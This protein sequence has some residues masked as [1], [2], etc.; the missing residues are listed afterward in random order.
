MGVGKRLAGKTDKREQERGKEAGE[1]R[2]AWR[3]A[4]KDGEGR[5]DGER[6]GRCVCVE[7]AQIEREKE[8][9]RGSRGPV[10][11]REGRRVQCGSYLNLFK[12]SLID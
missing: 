1:R 7:G 5:K 4:R 6:T 9:F 12:F 11:G 10:G 3:G 8:K 2:G